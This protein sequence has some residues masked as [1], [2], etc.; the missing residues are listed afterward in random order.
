MLNTCER[1]DVLRTVTSRK[2][3][4]KS[5]ILK[6]QS[7]FSWDMAPQGRVIISMIGTP[8]TSLIAVTSCSMKVQESSESKQLVQF[9][10]CLNGSDEPEEI[11]TPEPAV[12]E[13][14]A[15]EPEPTEGEGNTVE[16]ESTDEN[17]NSHSD[18]EDVPAPVPQRI[19]ARKRNRPNLYGDWIFATADCEKEPQTV[20]EALNCAE[21]E[22]WK[23]AMRS[24]SLSTRMTYGTLWS[25]LKAERQWGASGYLKRKPRQMD[26]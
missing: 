9:E 26:R 21:K 5:W 6:Q 20:K 7:M 23:S 14:T 8:R 12:P 3:K 25:C 19:S 18:S 13:P 22:Q 1:L 15:P 16:A 4:E 10:D 11:V 17:E 24:D 2:M